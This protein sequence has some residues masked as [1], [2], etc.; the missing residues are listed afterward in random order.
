MSDNFFDI[1][2]IGE[3]K[4]AKKIKSDIISISRSNLPVLIY[5]ETGTGKEIV[6][7]LIHRSGRRKDLPFV[8]L[9]AASLPDNL[10]ISELFGFEKGAFTG[11]NKRKLGLFEIADNG[12]LF[13]DEIG[14]AG[15]E[16]Q[17]LLIRTIDRK[18]IKRLG[19]NE[20]IKVNTR[21]ISA[22]NRFPLNQNFSN[23]LLLRLSALKIFNPPVRERREDIPLLVNH[24]IN[25]FNLRSAKKVRISKEALEQLTKFDYPGNVREL[26]NILERIVYLKKNKEITIDDIPTPQLDV[27]KIKEAYNILE[28]KEELERTKKEINYLKR[29]TIIANPI[30]QGKGFAKEKDYCF[31]LMPFAD[32]N[33]LQAVYNEHI[34]NVIENKCGL[35]CERA[36]D[37]YDISGIMQSVWESINKATLIIADLTQ[38]NPNVFY[39][40]GIAHT[41]GKPVIIITQS[42]DFVPFD[43]R[44]LRCILYGYTPKGIKKFEFTLEKTV[45]SVL[46]SEHYPDLELL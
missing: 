15:E 41:L 2:F 21:I 13:L 5:G 20:E 8:V 6:A 34:K 17:K 42:M 18:V 39:E 43:L 22:T 31:V 14:D 3:S 23:D 1:K 7:E 28:L 16:V 45:Q 32:Q 33:D 36:D 30:W 24:F 19:S 11:A 29:T 44:H 38:R 4:Q 35:R 27:I 12:T 37:I 25:E 40:L 26:R 46:S 10:A 9:N